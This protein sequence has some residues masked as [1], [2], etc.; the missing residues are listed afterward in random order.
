[1]NES[2][3]SNMYY[4]DLSEKPTS[5]RGIR[6]CSNI[7]AATNILCQHVLLWSSLYVLIGGIYMLLT[8]RLDREVIA[9]MI[10]AVTAVGR[11]CPS[12]RLTLLRMLRPGNHNNR[13]HGAAHH[14]CVLI[15]TDVCGAEE[16]VST[17]AE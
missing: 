7:S 14:C 15:N 16:R 3:M 4:E 5:M 9:A 11:T 6:G 12:R 17:L 1:M 10:V 2:L 8:I 13:L